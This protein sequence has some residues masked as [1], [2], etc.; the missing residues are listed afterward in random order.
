VPTALANSCITVNG[1]P[2]PLIFVSPAQINAQMPFQAVGAETIVVHTPGGTSD[3]F[4]LMVQPTAPA[5]F[6]SGVAGPQTNLPTIMRLANGLLAT[7]SNPI[8]PNDTLVIYVTGLG[9]T[10]PSGLTGYPAPGNPLANALT[11]TSVTLGGMNLPVGY[12]G[13][14]PGEVGVYQI[15]VTVPGNIPTGLSLPL[16]INQG[17]GTSSVSMRVIP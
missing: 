17:E 10:N 4:N 15:N 7:D 9:Q 13:L 8:K 1:Q 16:V 2:I 14:A 12:A 5:V 11:P 6:M 3:N